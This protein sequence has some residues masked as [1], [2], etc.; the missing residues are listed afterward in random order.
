[1]DIEPF[2]NLRRWLDLIRA[3]PA[4]DKGIKVP[5]DITEL[6]DSDDD[7]AAEEFAKNARTMV[8]QGRSKP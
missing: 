7:E 6:L 1:V 8:E 3:R 5:Y 2:P 4:A